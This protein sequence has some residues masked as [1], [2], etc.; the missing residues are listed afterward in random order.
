MAL[1]CCRAALM[2]PRLEATRR[3][4]LLFAC[5][6]RA[7]A[8]CPRQGGRTWRH[9][10]PADSSPPTTTTVRSQDTRR[11]RLPIG[12]PTRRSPLTAPGPPAVAATA[13]RIQ[14]PPALDDDGFAT[15]ATPG[16]PSTG[17]RRLGAI[18]SDQ[19][20]RLPEAECFAPWSSTH[21]ASSPFGLRSGSS[22][23][24]QAAGPARPPPRRHR[25][26]RTACTSGSAPCDDRM[27]SGGLVWSG[28]PRAGVTGENGTCSTASVGDS[29]ARCASRATIITFR[30][31]ALAQSGRRASS[32]EHPAAPERVYDHRAATVGLFGRLPLD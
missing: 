9:L 19:S 18:G 29:L 14:R 20:S 22:A 11:T 8:P 24:P 1:R 3:A 27:P 5:A 31:I 12:S 30:N 10:P 6:S 13:R 15:G 21:S 16:S 32:L 25:P 7:T 2:R 4:P 17:S 23:W 28:A 26:G